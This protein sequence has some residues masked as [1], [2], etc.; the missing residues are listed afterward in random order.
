[1]MAWAQKE[2]L[3]GVSDMCMPTL[4]LNCRSL[5]TSDTV[6]PAV[7]QIKVFIDPAPR[8]RSA[9]AIIRIRW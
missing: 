4:D 9:P 1:M 3:R 8:S 6:G 7:V 2:I 5:S